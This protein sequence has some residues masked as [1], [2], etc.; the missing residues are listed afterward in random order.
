MKITVA[1]SVMIVALLFSACL[2]NEDN[3]AEG[4]KGQLAV[5][6]VSFNTA[7]IDL[8]VDKNKVTTT[9]VAFGT[10]SGSAGNNY[11]SVQAGLRQ[12]LLTGASATYLDKMYAVDANKYYSMFVFD[13]MKN[14]LANVYILNDDTTT[15]DTLAKARFF[16][17]IPGKDTLSALLIKTNTSTDTAL[18]GSNV[19]Y[20]SSVTSGFPV[21]VKPGSYRLELKRSGSI[22][23]KDTPVVIQARK[24]YSFIAKGVSGGMGSNSPSILLLQNK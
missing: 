19:T 3:T 20:L 8:T 12:M 24:L 18:L 9:P 6:N 17:F 21:L 5:I 13:T 22:I 15:V 14:N 4:P 16:H 7:A 11:L 1:I 2:K 23:Y 10:A